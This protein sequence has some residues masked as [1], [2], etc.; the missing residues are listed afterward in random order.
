METSKEKIERLLKDVQELIN[1]LVMSNESEL[2][3]SAVRRKNEL[4]Q[5]L[6]D[7]RS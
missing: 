1:E 7:I 5:Q 6:K 3:E 4:L 2:L